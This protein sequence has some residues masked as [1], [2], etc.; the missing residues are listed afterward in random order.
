MKKRINSNPKKQIN[1]KID[2][3]I[4][5][6]RR[7]KILSAIAIVFFIF[8]VI[9]PSLR[10]ITIKSTLKT[11]IA[12]QHTIYKTIDVEAFA[13]RKEICLNTTGVGGTIVPAVKNGSKVSVGDTVANIF[14][15]ENSAVN[16]SRIDELKMEID[17]YTGI[18]SGSVGTL[19]TDIAVYNNSVNNA[20]FELSAAIDNNDLSA[21]YGLSR[22]VRESVTKKQIVTGVKVDVSGILSKLTEEYNLLRTD[23]MP[24][25]GIFTDSAGYYVN[26]VDGYE[27]T[28]NFDAVKE[29]TWD[30]VDRIINSEPA[31]LPSNPVGKIITDFNW[32]LV[33]N[34]TVDALEIKGIDSDVTV[35]F[36][37]S[38]VEQIR[39]SIEKINTV[40]GTDKVTLILKSNLM[41]ENIAELRKVPVKIRVGS[42]TGLSVDKMA[43]R[44]VDGE[45]GVYVKVGNLVD[46]K[47]I[48]ILYSDDTIVLVKQSEDSD[49]LSFYDEVILEG[50]GLYEAKLLN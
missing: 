39:M 28:V 41:N 11:Q 9:F 44:T 26:S 19:Q 42:V 3:E 15:N 37:N 50:T 20:V 2:Y 24:D 21:I 23:F 16:A 27:N 47:L 14:F 38:Q 10:L 35:I 46:F 45:K 22:D 29:L 25:A 8:F 31:S 43:L 5:S 33:C 13:V 36:G 34:T 17:Y 30:E 6:P 12:V 7:K 48:D 40:P 4:R 32:Y 18:V 49:Y 1:T